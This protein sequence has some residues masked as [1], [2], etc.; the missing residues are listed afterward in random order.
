MVHAAD[1]FVIAGHFYKMGTYE[2]LQS[3]V[4]EFEHTS[5]LIKAHGGMA[6]GHYIGKVIAQQKFHVGLWRP[7]LHKDSREFCRACDSCQRMGKPLQGDE[8]PLNPQVSLQV[9][10]KLEI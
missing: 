5:I 8:V 7:T 9:F 6:R 4:L 1:F 10:D 3:Y 2:I